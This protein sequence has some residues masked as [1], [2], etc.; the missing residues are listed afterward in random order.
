ML[1]IASLHH[2]GLKTLHEKSSEV[3]GVLKKPFAESHVMYDVI[4]L[5]RLL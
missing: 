1:Y 2:A 5:S 3:H 4:M